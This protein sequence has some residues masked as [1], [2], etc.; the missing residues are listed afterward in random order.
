MRDDADPSASLS[1]KCPDCGAEL[2]VDRL[3]GEIVSHRAPAKKSAGGK[4]FDQLLAGLDRQKADAEK[5]FEKERVALREHGRLMDAKFEE[6]LKR[7]RDE[8][9]DVPPPS[10]FDAD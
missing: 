10:P 2:V 8:P 5:T 4:D 1:L 9:D 6:A 3:T 7:A